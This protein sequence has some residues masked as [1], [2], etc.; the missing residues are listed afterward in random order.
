MISGEEEGRGVGVGRE[1]GVGVEVGYG[2]G[3][4]SVWK[5]SLIRLE[6]RVGRGRGVVREKEFSESIDGMVR[7]IGEIGI[8]FMELRLASHSK[9]VNTEFSIIGMGLVLWL[10]GEG[11][12]II[13]EG[14][15]S[16]QISL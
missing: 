8:A 15:G 1:V 5:G 12:G 7:E 16:A 6:L 3:E 11:V 4:R 10:G 13:K 9:D 2:M 14:K